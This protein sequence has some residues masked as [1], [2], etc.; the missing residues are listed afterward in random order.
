L[1]KNI[2]KPQRNAKIAQK[3]TKESVI[4]ASKERKDFTKEHRENYN[5]LLSFVKS[6]L[7]FEVETAFLRLHLGG[8]PARRENFSSI[9]LRFVV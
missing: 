1:P 3:N 2:F 5:L 9:L 8:E 7:S 6:L 4:S